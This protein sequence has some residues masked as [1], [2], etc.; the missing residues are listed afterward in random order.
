MR[1]PDSSLISR[2]A[3]SGETTTS[4]LRVGIFGG[5][6][7]T[8]NLGVSALGI[9]SALGVLEARPD[10]QLTLFDYGNGVRERVLHLN[11]REHRIELCGASYSRRYYRTSNEQVA[12]LF[13]RLGLGAL[14][15]LARRIREM[16]AILD[17]SGGDS[18]SDMYGEWVFRS[19]TAPKRLVL[20]CNRPLFLLP[21]TYGPFSDP[22]VR[23]VARSLIGAASM[24]WARDD[25]SLDVVANVLGAD[26]DQSRHQTGV[27]V[28]FGLPVSESSGSALRGLKYGNVNAPAPVFG[29]N[30]SGL[31]YNGSSA[32]DR[33]FGLAVSYR[34]LVRE[35]AIRLL[36]T[37]RSRLL[38]IPH[39][40][41]PCSYQE[42]DY[43]ACCDL[44]A[45]LPEELRTRA[46]I[47]TPTLDPTEV[48]ASIGGCDW[49]CGSR[50]HACIAGLSQAVPTVNIAYSDKSIG[51]FETAGEGD[52]VFD[53]RELSAEAVLDGIMATV[54]DRASAR[55]RLEGMQEGLKRRC[56][57][58]F[59]D[60]MNSVE[61]VKRL[62]P[63]GEAF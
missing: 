24:V 59:H 60:L 15:P 57:A 43:R 45:R 19:V 22:A 16:D 28:A 14:H 55:V 18:F 50:M 30:V 62:S 5:A 38:L 7:D 37:E 29:L 26:F 27:D 32:S 51:V 2:H 33:R 54:R 23:R 13:A 40:V 1:R 8:G 36:S 10:A 63:K 11:G 46:E 52:A 41:E 6:L 25:R 56:R 53:P 58:Q 12:S 39:V 31:I 48:K 21:Q 34:D 47:V 49:F 42:D 17:V 61:A 4:G 44:H 9:G 35:L 3:R 20:N